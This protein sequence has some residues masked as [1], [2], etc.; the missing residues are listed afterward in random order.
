MFNVR[1]VLFSL[2]LLAAGA[3]GA[4]LYV[5]SDRYI[6]TD[7]AYLKFDKVALSSEVTGN[8][9]SIHVVENQ[10][11]KSGDLLLT[12]DDAVY[13][14]AQEKAAARVQQAESD[15]RSL[16]ASYRTKEAQLALAVSDLEFADKEYRR[17]LNLSRQNLTSEASIDDRK[18]TLDIANERRIIIEKE[19]AQL[20]ANLNGRADAPVG[21]YSA[22]ME[23]Q[24]DLDLANI[25]LQ[26]TRVLAP[27]DGIVSHLPKL[28]QHLDPGSALL[29]LV[30]DE[31]PWIE[32]NF[33]ETDLADLRVGQAVDIT[34]DAYPDHHWRGTVESVSAATGAEYSV[35]P[36]QN[37]TGNWIKV[38]QRVPIR[39]ALQA[40][41]AEPALRAGMS[42][43]VEIDTHAPAP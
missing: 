42:A 25:N 9:T 41:Q 2:G 3:V 40:Q 35:L 34:V 43:Y 27:F 22:V 8:I 5:V 37:A 36:P 15:I 19:R 11:V 38:V 17:E 33:K 31:N 20:L 12:V 26:H 32:A 30:S 16:Q 7:N 29:S 23:A 39:I 10:S 14:V 1:T 6:S 28:G 4:Y 21:Q 18:H 13:R 24:A